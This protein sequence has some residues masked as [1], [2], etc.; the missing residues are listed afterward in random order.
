VPIYADP[1]T[2][3]ILMRRFEYCFVQPP[4]SLYPAI[5]DAR[6]LRP[7]NAARSNRRQNCAKTALV[8]AK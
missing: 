1:A 5:L 2:R 3:D 4:G 8:G 7:P 6:E